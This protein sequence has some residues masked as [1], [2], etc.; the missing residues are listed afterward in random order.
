MK[1]C[2]DNNHT[3]TSLP[4]QEHKSSL[5]IQETADFE[6]LNALAKGGWKTFLEVGAALVEVRDR[7][8]FRAN[9]QSFSDYCK[10]ELGCSKAYAYS[11]MGSAEVHKQLSAIADFK[12]IPVNE[13]QCR[14]LLPVAADKRPEVLK[15]AVVMAGEGPLTA[16]IV[17]EAAVEFTTKPSKN[18]KAAQKSTLDMTAGLTLLDA[19]E[20]LAEGDENDALIEKVAELREWLSVVLSET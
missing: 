18:T 10:L 3:G 4:G 8:L 20:E 16:K 2:Y 7:G 9:Y 14:A 11:L 19:I 17:R 6:R 13:A 1:T 15:K 5:T 12:I